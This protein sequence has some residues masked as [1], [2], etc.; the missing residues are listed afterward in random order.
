MC[1][2]CLE[3]IDEL[4]VS[5]FENEVKYLCFSFTCSWLRNKMPGKSRD[6]HQLY[7]MLIPLQS[8]F[9]IQDT[10]LY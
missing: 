6:V 2:L 3:N 8:I 5:K 1:N 9:K 7:S 4:F 10:I